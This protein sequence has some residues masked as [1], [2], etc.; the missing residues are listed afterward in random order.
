MDKEFKIIYLWLC[1]FTLGIA[2]GLSLLANFAQMEKYSKDKDDCDDCYQQLQEAK[3]KYDELYELYQEAVTNY[4]ETEKKYQDAY[5]DY[6]EAEQ[7]Y[8]DAL[9]DY[10]TAQDELDKIDENTDFSGKFY[11]IVDYETNFGSITYTKPIHITYSLYF[12]YRLDLAHPTHSSS[13]LQVTADILETYC[14]VSS[15]IVSIAQSIKD[16]CNDPNNN[17]E[18]VDALLSFCQ[19]KGDDSK[20]IIYIEDGADDFAKYPWETIAEGN[21]DCEDKSILFGSLVTALGYSAAILVV[22]GHVLVGVNLL[23]NPTHNMQY[24]TIWSVEINGDK[25]YTCETTVDGWL[26]GDLPPES[27]G[28]TVYYKLID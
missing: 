13:N 4:E 22:P 17:E 18:V 2:F 19:H 28:E 3:D 25:Y 21:G 10:Q 20:S 8:Q 23:S 27:Q 14:I 7:N 1:C 15:G 24:P 26:I 16:Q 12:H 9:E 5:K 11:T 6:L